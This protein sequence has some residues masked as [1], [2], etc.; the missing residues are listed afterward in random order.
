MELKP[1]NKTSTHNPESKRKDPRKSYR[2]LKRSSFLDL[3]LAPFYLFITLKLH[4]ILNF[5]RCEGGKSVGKSEE[6]AHHTI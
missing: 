1:M 6:K 4:V 3:S 5:K 2:D